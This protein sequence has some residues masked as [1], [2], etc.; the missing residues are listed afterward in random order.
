MNCAVNQRL[1]LTAVNPICIASLKFYYLIGACK[2][3]G[4]YNIYIV[5]C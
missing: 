2:C 1:M 5:C 3:Q 4:W